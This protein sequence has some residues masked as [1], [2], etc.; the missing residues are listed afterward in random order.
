MVTINL[1]EFLEKESKYSDVK[2]KVEKCPD[3]N[4]YLMF[5]LTSTLINV[6]SGSE[7][8]SMMSGALGADVMS[9]DSG[10]ES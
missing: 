6:T 9:M 8:M 1:G 10:P 5:D 7:T 3:E 4:A 2:M